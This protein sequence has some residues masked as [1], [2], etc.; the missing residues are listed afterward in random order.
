MRKS[1]DFLNDRIV[2]LIYKVFIPSLLATSVTLVTQLASTFFMG[3][4][5]VISLYVVGLF[6]PF[7]FFITAII[8]GFSISAGATVAVEK[9]KNNLEYIPKVILNY[10]VYGVIIALII[11]VIITL[12]IPLLVDFFNVHP[13]AKDTFVNYTMLM[14]FI[15]ILIVLNAIFYAGLRGYGLVKLASFISVFISLSDILLVFIFVKFL[16]MGVYSIVLANFILMTVSIILGLYFLIKKDILRIKIKKINLQFLKLDP[17]VKQKLLSIGIPVMLS[18]ILI[19]FSTFFFN[20]I[21][22]PFGEEVVAGFGAAYRVQT[23]AIAIGIAFGGA[24]GLIMNQNIGGTKLD[25]SYD[26]FKKGLIHI[27]GIYIII[28]VFVFFASQTIASFLI[29]DAETAQ[30]ASNYLK[31]VGLSY[32]FMGPMLTTLIVMEQLGKGV[33]AFLLN[34]FYFAIIVVLG[35]L[36]T[37][38]YQQVEIFYWTIS[39]MNIFSIVGIGYGLFTIKR[40]LRVQKM[41]LS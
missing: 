6:L 29:A 37:N 33:H 15:N 8:E 36:L 20:K 40:M 22:M 38:K 39:I 2:P 31:I 23:M 26:T 16:R 1:L 19:F 17:T 5:D 10:A 3:H 27:F 4:D 34:F 18:Y 12:F 28:G 7:S 25:R 32:T 30:H 21:V 24:I 35:W 41:E 14:L 11:A 9:G 13:T